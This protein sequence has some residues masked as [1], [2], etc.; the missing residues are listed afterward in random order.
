MPCILRKAN[1]NE[2]IIL[3]ISTRAIVLNI[4]IQLASIQYPPIDLNPPI[5]VV[6][7]HTFWT[8]PSI[9]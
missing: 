7:T 2:V 4:M 9:V 3:N 5:Y 6:L 8:H 1:M